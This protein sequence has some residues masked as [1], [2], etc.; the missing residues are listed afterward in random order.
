MYKNFAKPIFDFII[1]LICLPFLLLIIIPVGLAI[2]IDDRG[3]IFYCGKRVGRN[4]KTFKMVKFRTMKVNAPDI[5]LNDG[6][7][8][9]A[10]DDPRV[11]KVGRFLRKTSIDELPQIFNILIFQMSFIGPRPDPVDWLDK[12]DDDEKDFLKLRPGITGYS[13]AYF[14]NSEDGYQKVKNDNYY[15]HHI[16]LWYDIKILFKTVAIV[17]KSENVYVDDCRMG[18]IE[19][20]NLLILGAGVLQLP[21]IKKAKELGM[22]VG[23]VDYDPNAIGIKRADRYFNCSTLDKE[24]ALKASEDFNADGIMTMATDMPMRTLAYVCKDRNLVGISED[25]A[26]NCTDKLQMITLFKE[27][28]VSSP[29][30]YGI[31]SFDDLERAIEEIGFPCILKPTDNSGSRGVVLL[32]S[33]ENLSE[34]YNY[35]KTSSRSGNALLEEY[36]VGPE[37]SVEVFAEQGEAHVLQ[38]TDKVTTGAPHFVELGHSQPSRLA[39]GIKEQIV[40]LAQR[41]CNA[42]GLFAGPAHLEMII[43]E[44]GPKM[45]EMGARMGGDCITSHL[46]PLSTGIDMTEQTIRY[47]LGMPVNLRPKTNKASAVVFLTASSGKIV[48]I[49]NIKRAYRVEGIREIGFFKAV[50]DEC[51]EINSS[52]DRIGYVI[53]QAKTAQKAIKQCRRAAKRIKIQVEETK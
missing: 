16:S 38:I 27:N 10:N 21:A 39:S 31:G 13:Q 20:K 9:N 49:G 14:R 51:G 52:S 11:T 34:N 3:P 33:R 37:V 1:A 44:S 30:F 45:V 53:S 48:K 50:G 23:V 22:N 5:R 2:K 40:E 17:F 36:M 15:Y 18:A 43:T 12:Y 32:E 42:V 19:K 25:C 26:F 46:V 4:G 7:T 47:A 6:S 28:N 41:A 35:V 29:R 24:G 8:Y